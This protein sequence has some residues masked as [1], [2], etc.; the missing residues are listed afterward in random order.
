[1]LEL[2]GRA[3][4]AAAAAEAGF[5][6]DVLLSRGEILRDEGGEGG[7]VFRAAVKT[8]EE[9]EFGGELAALAVLLLAL[10]PVFL[11]FFRPAGPA[12]R[13]VGM[14]EAERRE[15]A[16]LE[17]QTEGDAGAGAVGATRGVASR[18]RSRS[19][20]TEPKVGAGAGAGTDAGHAGGGLPV[21]SARDRDRDSACDAAES[22]AMRWYCRPHAKGGGCCCW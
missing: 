8:D 6:L 11:C 1:M 3:G 10:L 21:M 18:S 20:S 4:I 14:L 16:T 15:A 13:P 22:L 9:A 17:T 7:E 5:A 2:A 19:R 12:P